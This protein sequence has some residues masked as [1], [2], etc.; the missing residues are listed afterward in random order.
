MKN[1]ELEFWLNQMGAK[2]AVDGV[3]GPKSQAAAK[4]LLGDYAAEWE[5]A[6]LALAVEQSVMKIVGY[7]NVG[8]IDGIL[9]PATRKARLHWLRGP[10]RNGVIDAVPADKRFPEL[11]KTIWPK[12]EDL[13]EFFGEPGQNLTTI[14]VPFPLKLSWSTDTVVYKVTCHKLVADSLVRVQRNILATYGYMEIE[15]LRLDVFGGCYA[16]RPMRGANKLSTHAWGIAWDTNPVENAL[17]YNHKQAK[18]AQP[19]FNKFWEAWTA[20]GWLSLGKA[21]DFDW[22]HTQACQ[23]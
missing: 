12:Y 18:L 7:L 23:L 10:W 2:L 17:R 15:R 13:S 16:A 5:P 9:G 14:S 21:R 19:V 6:R 11:V 22:M 4:Q 8:P 20:E 1:F 3:F